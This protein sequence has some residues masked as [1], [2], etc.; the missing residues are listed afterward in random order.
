MGSEMC[1]RDRRYP[2]PGRG[3]QETVRRVASGDGRSLDGR[4]KLSLEWLWEGH[5]FT[6]AE[7]L[8]IACATVEERPFRAALERKKKWALAPVRV[9]CHQL[10]EL[11]EI[12]ISAADHAYNL[13][14]S[15]FAAEPRGHCACGRAFADQMIPRGDQRHRA[16]RFF[17]RSHD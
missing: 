5:E 12:D 6:A 10:R 13:P 3:N 11:A 17:E 16:G 8:V 4:E 7:K 1:I 9:S 14:T 15:C 2:A